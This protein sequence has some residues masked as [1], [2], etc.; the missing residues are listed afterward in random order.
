MGIILKPFGVYRF[1]RSH[2]SLQRA[3]APIL[4]QFLARAIALSKI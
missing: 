1:R 2:S 4:Q 3:I